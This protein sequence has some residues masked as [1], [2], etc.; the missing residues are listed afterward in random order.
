MALAVY[1]RVLFA[2]ST[3]LPLLTIVPIRRYLSNRAIDAVVRQGCAATDT[4]VSTGVG[5]TSGGHC[6]ARERRPIDP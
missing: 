3:V 6:P 4:P 2:T 5:E 1:A